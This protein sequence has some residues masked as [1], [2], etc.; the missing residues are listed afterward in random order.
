MYTPPTPTTAEA[1]AFNAAISDFKAKGAEVF[2]ISRVRGRVPC[3]C[4][5]HRLIGRPYEK[6]NRPYRTNRR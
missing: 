1:K 5:V 6:R 2:G 3:L 4:F